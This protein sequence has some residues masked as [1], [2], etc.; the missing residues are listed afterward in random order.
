MVRWAISHKD[1]ERFDAAKMLTAWAKKR[2]AS[3]P[4]IPPFICANLISGA[5]VLPR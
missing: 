4:P 2:E 1:D 3:Q 5:S